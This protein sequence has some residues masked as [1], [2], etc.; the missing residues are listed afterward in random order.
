MGTRGYPYRDTR[1]DMG[2][3][4]G[5]IFIQRGG[6]EYHTTR[7]RGYPLTSLVWMMLDIYYLENNIDCVWS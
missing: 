7:T 3:G 6:D 1:T 5:T 2:T 4:M